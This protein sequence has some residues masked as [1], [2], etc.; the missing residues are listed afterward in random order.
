MYAS[1]DLAT[2]TMQ[3]FALFIKC[4]FGEE[5]C[6]CPFSSIRRL[7]LC[8]ENR[9]RLAERIAA[10]EEQSRYMWQAHSRCYRQRLSG[11][12]RQIRQRRQVSA[13]C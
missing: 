12:N 11:L 8:L 7:T 13:T 3:F 10:N 4:P 5:D 2:G 1:H 6:A 9:F